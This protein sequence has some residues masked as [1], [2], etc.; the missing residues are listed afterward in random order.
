MARK[1]FIVYLVYTVIVFLF[2]N[3]VIKAN[4]NYADSILK[5]VLSGVVFTAVYAILLSRAAKR[6]D[7]K[8]K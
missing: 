4:T 8:K 6:E 3:Y 1:I 7:E 5:A 2:Y